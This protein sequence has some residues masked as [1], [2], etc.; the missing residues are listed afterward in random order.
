MKKIL[1]ITAFFVFTAG[2][3]SADILD[4]V[5]LIGDGYYRD[6][7]VSGSA[8]H[9][10]N[11]DE[12]P[13]NKVT[14][15]NYTRVANDRDSYVV[16]TAVFPEDSVITKI[17]ISPCASGY[18]DAYQVPV[19]DVFYR[20]AGTDSEDKG[21]Y[22]LASHNFY[23]YPYSSFE[24]IIPLSSSSSASTTLEI[25]VVKDGDSLGGYARVSAFK[26]RFTYYVATTSSAVGEGV[27]TREL[28]INK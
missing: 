5:S 1:I 7:S 18:Y 21:D 6:W 16:D 23:Q 3:V 12:T 15:Y 25:G 24:T 14:D 13:C 8:I 26:A 2:I 10:K 4:P 19:L 27:F 20:Y 11:V 17:E 22:Y 9:Y 28:K